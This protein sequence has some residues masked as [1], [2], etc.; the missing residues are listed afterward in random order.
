MQKNLRWWLPDG[1]AIDE[2]EF[3]TRHRII[4]TALSLHV[5]VLVI[6]GLFN[7]YS[8]WHAMAETAPV[9]GFSLFAQRPGHRVIRSSSASLGLVYAASVLVHFADGIIEAH[10][11]W[12][13]VLTLA[14]LYVDIRPFV[15]AVGYTAV[16]HFA[17]SLY[18]PTL[19]FEHERGQEN[20]FLWT[21]VH[22]VFVVMLIG[23]AAINW[24]ALQI[25]QEERA[26]LTRLREEQAQAR[27]HQQELVAEQSARLAT[28]SNTVQSTIS[29][30][31][32]A[33]EAS[34]ESVVQ[35]AEAVDGAAEMARRAREEAGTT[36]AAVVELS[37]QSQEITRM[38]ELITEIAGRTTLLALN[39]AIEAARAGASGK[40]FAVVA[41][42]V[43]NLAQSTT[44]AT[45][46]VRV[47]T[48]EIESKID[49]AAERV[50]TLAE[51]VDQVGEQ[52]QLIEQHMAQHRE[53]M[54]STHEDVDTA[55]HTMLPIIE[56]INQ[57]NQLMQESVSRDDELADDSL[58]PA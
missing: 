18:D 47:L 52:H 15:A 14:S 44:D 34:G 1:H 39:A 48:N 20:P 49:D 54:T 37:T 38:V 16:H 41:S 10:F 22:V 12:F 8:W 13:V 53:H 58:A 43:R 51:F 40:G 32:A 17:M 7:G 19:V 25:G 2:R 55:A 33:M 56:G 46:E 21:M 30:A 11:H 28:E 45:S 9:L 24:I 26:E 31:S 5:P 50:K 6:I 42:E 29:G 57:L 35:A 36:R 3:E 4:T 23:S 27:A